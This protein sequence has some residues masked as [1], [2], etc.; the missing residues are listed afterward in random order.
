MA[1]MVGEDHRVYATVNQ[2]LYTCG[3][4]V[5]SFLERMCR[6]VP[7]IKIGELSV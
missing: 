4:D 6:G 5:V 3:D 1:L 7:P 2:F